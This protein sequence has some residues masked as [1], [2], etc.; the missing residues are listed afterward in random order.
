MLCVTPP[1][2]LNI[3]PHSIRKY[4]HMLQALAD[5]TG[6]VT[7]QTYILPTGGFSGYSGIWYMT[8]STLATPQ[9]EEIRKE[10]KALE[11]LVLS[12]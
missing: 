11:G 5:L 10:I 6:C 2:P 7:T 1:H 8:S 9:Q 4:Q 3:L 12:R